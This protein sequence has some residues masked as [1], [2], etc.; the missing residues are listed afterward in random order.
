M[1]KIAAINLSLKPLFG[2]KCFMNIFIANVSKY[3]RNDW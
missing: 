3:L 2:K 1:L